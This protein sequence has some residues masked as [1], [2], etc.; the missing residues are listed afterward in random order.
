MKRKRHSTPPGWTFGEHKYPG[1]GW[2]FGEC[3]DRGCRA[4]EE[5][6]DHAFVAALW[7]KD[8]NWDL[9]T[10][11]VT[12]IF[13]ATLRRGDACRG[14]D[15]LGSEECNA[16]IEEI[17]ILRDQE[18]ARIDKAEHR[19]SDVC[20]EWQSVDTYEK[21]LTDLLEWKANDATGTTQPEEDRGRTVTISGNSGQTVKRK[22]HSASPGRTSGECVDMGQCHFM[23]SGWTFGECVDRG[24]GKQEEP[25]DHASVAA[26]WHEDA[27]WDLTTNLVSKIFVDTL[28]HGGACRGLDILGPEECDARIKEIKILRGQEYER[29]DEAKH[30]QSDVCV[31]WQSVGTYEKHLTDLLEWK[32]NNAAGTT[33]PEAEHGLLYL[34]YYY[35]LA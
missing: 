11:L 16:R 21:H 30:R 3:V 14:L 15:I 35:Q 6:D 24:R 22:R 2:T 9:T 23:G 1:E 7:H 13:V 26:L 12:K 18:Y 28:Q 29:I 10:N 33:E 17:K 31:E 8:A 5:T 32:A 19:Q 25:D 20:V 27:N 4:K 34:Q